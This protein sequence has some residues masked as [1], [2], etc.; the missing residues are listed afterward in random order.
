MAW[1]ILDWE[2]L[3]DRQS[4][5]PSAH[6]GDNGHWVHPLCDCA[7]LDETARSYCALSHVL[8]DHLQT[9]KGLFQQRHALERD[10]D[11]TPLIIGITG[12][13]AVGKSTTAKLLRKLLSHWPTSPKVDIVASDGFLLPR[14]NLEAIGLKQKKGFPESY[15]TDAIIRFL[16]A[17]KS[18]ARVV[19]APVYSHELHDIVPG[20]RIRIEQPD[21]LIFEGLNVLQACNGAA[22]SPRG[23]AI[24]DF[25]DYS[26]YIDA[27]VDHIRR[28][29]IQRFMQLRRRTR[30][31]SASPV[32]WGTCRSEREASE[33]AATIWRDVNAPNLSQNILPTLPLAD[34]V[35]RKGA[36]HEVQ[37]VVLKTP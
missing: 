6:A 35:L 12:S 9:M 8:F 11:D 29:Y 26:I 32:E 36:N 27:E 30:P 2:R 33:I 31:A 5:P 23:P 15:D 18:G 10:T 7:D 25:I 20:G 28:W 1:E 16:S 19:E 22:W 14:A 21:I 37:Q 34:L 17:L 13:V 24:S 3:L 4:L